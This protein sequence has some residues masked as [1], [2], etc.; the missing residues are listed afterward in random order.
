M[1]KNYEAMMKLIDALKRLP[2]TKGVVVVL[3][4]GM[5]ST[6]AMRLCVEKYGAENVRALTFDYGQKQKIE[7]QRAKI[8]T[9]RYGVKHRVFDLSV[10][11]DI[12]KGFS[13]NVDSDIKMPTIKEVLGDP[14]PKT[15]VPNRNMILMSVASA[16]AEVEGLDTVIMG[17]Q[18][19]DEYG[20]HDT[21]ARFVNKINDVLSE[22]RIIKIKV[23]A[24]FASL[25]KVDELR[26]LK[27]LEGN[28]SLTQYTLT[29]YNPNDEGESCGKCPSCSERIA[30]FMMMGEKDPISYSVDIPWRQMENV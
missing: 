18:I 13:A 6:I 15:Y 25:S 23:I 17:L 14:R 5:D 21:T 10:L 24:P 12:S 1:S 2:D 11:G 22:N 19:H 28:L 30:N 4:G 9:Y 20:Y 7:I 27:E 16:F 3:S 8:S 29:C 26:I